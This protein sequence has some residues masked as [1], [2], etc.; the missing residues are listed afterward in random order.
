VVFV[1]HRAETLITF[2]LSA[3][4]ARALGRPARNGILTLLDH[5]H[6]NPIQQLVCHLC[7]VQ[8]SQNSKVSAPVE[9]PHFSQLW[10]RSS[11][12]TNSRKVSQASSALRDQARFRTPGSRRPKCFR[13]TDTHRLGE[14]ENA[15]GLDPLLLMA[16]R[17]APVPQLNCLLQASVLRRNYSGRASPIYGH[18]QTLLKNAFLKRKGDNS[19]RPAWV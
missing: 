11:G 10:R 17:D 1:D 6:S 3:A 13:G 16:L 15:R 12:C 14:V 2:S 9:L 5:R 19:Q 7:K 4:S 18:R 8:V